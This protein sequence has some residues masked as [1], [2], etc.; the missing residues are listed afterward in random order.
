MHYVV[1]GEGTTTIDGERFEWGPGD[2]V[3]LPP[4]AEHAYANRSTTADAWLFHVNDH[5]AL[6]KLGLW[7]EA[8]S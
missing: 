1:R 8:R 7:R 2:F 5:P 4:W 6:Q 3:A